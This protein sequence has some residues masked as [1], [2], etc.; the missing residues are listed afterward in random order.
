ME[1]FLRAYYEHF[2]YQSIDSYQFKEYFLNYFKDHDQDKLS[3]IEWD[4]WFKE[5]GMPLYKPHYDQSLAQTCN[6]LRQKWV[7]WKENQE[8]TC[9]FTTSQDFDTLSSDQKI[10]FLGQ[11]IEEEQA[12]SIDKLK[13]ME[14]LYQLS[15]YNNSEIKFNWIR[16]GLKG[17]WSDAVPRAV[18]MV[19]EQGR[20]KYL[21]PI[22]RD[23][24]N[25]ED[26]KKV[27]LETFEKNKSCMM[28]VA[29]QGLEND[30]K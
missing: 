5:P 22:Y 11:L 26:T 20:M 14:E 13:K 7:E 23:L 18:A 16:L 17:K 8:P 2:K 21:R 27:A 15:S 3:S 9:P 6:S 12:L 10:E 29:V 24:F 19:T 28:H 4:K 30:L 25:W 1:P